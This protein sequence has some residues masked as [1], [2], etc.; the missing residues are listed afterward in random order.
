MCS[1]PDGY[2]SISST[3][4]LPASACAGSS[5]FGVVKAPP[6]SQTRCH[7]ASTSC[8][9]YLS[10]S[11]PRYEKASRSR[12][13]GEADAAPPRVPPALLKKLRHVSDATALVAFE[14]RSQLRQLLAAQL[15]ALA[16]LDPVQQVV[17]HRRELDRV[18][19]LRDVVD[20]AEIDPARTVSQL[21][22]CRQ[23]DDRDARRRRILEQ[24]L[25]DP[26]AVE[27]RHHHVEQHHVG[28]LRPR[29]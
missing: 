4:A 24:L 2:G 5:G 1:S 26:P 28:L 17:D 20:P 29:R 15:V 6:S 21:G 11:R 3:Y 8:A 9:S 19:R 27:A 10:I 7:F 23:E 14:H 18:E 12:G 25:G 16:V 13:P 22:A